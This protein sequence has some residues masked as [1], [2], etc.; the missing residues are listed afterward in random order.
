VACQSPVSS[1][2]SCSRCWPRPVKSATSVGSCA[3]MV[4]T[5]V[6]ATSAEGAARAGAGSDGSRTRIARSSRCAGT[7]A[8][9]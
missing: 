3:G 9:A 8:R 4:Q 6:W 5:G 7:E 1:R 2:S